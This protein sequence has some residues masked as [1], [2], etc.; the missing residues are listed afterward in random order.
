[1]SLESSLNSQRIQLES[2]VFTVSITIKAEF[3]K[4]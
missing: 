1:M 3:L 4:F 2:E